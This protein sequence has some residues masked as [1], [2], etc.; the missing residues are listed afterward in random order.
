[1]ISLGSKWVHFSVSTSRVFYLK[2]F[3]NLTQLLLYLFFFLLLCVG[4]IYI[5]YKIQKLR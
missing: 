3:D 4:E 5:V 2:A 1:M